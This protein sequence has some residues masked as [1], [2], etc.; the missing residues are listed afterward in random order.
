[1]RT[2]PIVLYSTTPLDIHENTL[3]SLGCLNI[4]EILE[5]KLF[6]VKGKQSGIYFLQN[7]IKNFERKNRLLREEL[8]I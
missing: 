1:L 5:I 2:K 8:G 6:Q 4:E 3:Y 7:K